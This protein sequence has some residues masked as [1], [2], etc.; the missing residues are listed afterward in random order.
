MFF[1]FNNCKSF[2]CLLLMSVSC[3][4]FARAQA[5]SKELT[6]K[7]A[8]LPSNFMASM[9]VSSGLELR[10]TNAHRLDGPVLYQ[11]IFRSNATP[12][13]IPKISPRFTLT[14]SLINE[15]GGGLQ[16]GG[17][18]SVNAGGVFGFNSAGSGVYGSAIG[19]NFGVTGKGD[20]GGMQALNQLNGNAAYLATGC[21]AGYFTGDVQV[22]GNLTLTGNLI[23]GG[24]SFKIDHPLDPANKYLSHS[25]VESPD[26]MNI[27]NGNV[28]LDHRGEA[29]VD[30]PE[31]FEALNMDFRYQLTAIGVPGPNLYIAGPVTHNRFKIAG[32]K[33]YHQVSWQVTGIR[34]DAYANAHRIEVEQEKA[35]AEKGTYLYPELFGEPPEKS[36]SRMQGFEP[37][38][39][40]TSSVNATTKT[41]N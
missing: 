28:V 41:A 27:Y 13:A 24:G 33:P 17:P 12:G 22:S 29:W 16:I 14:N 25:F 21:C 26:M 36:L 40:S 37:K 31:W 3:G 20:N 18:V 1:S 7:S 15:V 5:A 11:I 10:R 6:A 38:Q 9:K 19:N 39:P 2:L 32:G 30:L 23:K 8:M 35:G 4:I 34:H